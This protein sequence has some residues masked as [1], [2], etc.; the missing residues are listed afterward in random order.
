MKNIALGTIA[1]L[2]LAPRLDVSQL[3]RNG[4]E[5]NEHIYGVTRHILREFNL[6]QLISIVDKML[7][8]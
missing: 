7:L 5:G 3:R 6:L 1:V 8:K 2:M 4:S